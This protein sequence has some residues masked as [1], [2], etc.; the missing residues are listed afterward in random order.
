MNNPSEQTRKMFFVSM[1]SES[2]TQSYKLVATTVS[3]KYTHKELYSLQIRGF[4]Y[5]N[6]KKTN[7]EHLDEVICW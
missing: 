7:I 4:W 1:K 2:K 6:I 5:P 3:L